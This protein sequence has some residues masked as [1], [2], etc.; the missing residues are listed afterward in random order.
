MIMKH[1]PIRSRGKK[2]GEESM[3]RNRGRSKKRNEGKEVGGKKV[4][5]RWDI[6]AGPQFWTPPH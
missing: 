1:D 6:K 4:N 5:G 3:G 2:G